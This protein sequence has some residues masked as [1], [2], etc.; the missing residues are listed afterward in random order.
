MNTET[1]E[2]LDEQHRLPKGIHHRNKNQNVITKD[3]AGNQKSAR[4]EWI[5]WKFSMIFMD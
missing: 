5:V 2:L 3:D 4:L 1:I